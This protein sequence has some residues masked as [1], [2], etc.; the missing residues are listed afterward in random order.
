MQPWDK[1]MCAY[2]SLRN[3]H[4]LPPVWQFWSVSQKD[5]WPELGALPAALT[6]DVWDTGPG[7]EGCY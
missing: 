3:C 7:T 6:D 4:N 1:L 2:V 5:D